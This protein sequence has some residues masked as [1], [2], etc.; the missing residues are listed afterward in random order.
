MTC[1]KGKRGQT[2]TLIERNVILDVLENF[3]ETMCKSKAVRACS[4]TT[5][6]S[7]RMIYKLAKEKELGILK[8]P[9]KC[10]RPHV[11]SHMRIMKYKS[12]VRSCIRRIVHSCFAQNIPP[13][14]NTILHTLNAVKQFP[15]FK[16]GTLYNLLKDIGFEYERRGGG[17]IFVER[18]D[19]LTY[20]HS[21]LQKLKEARKQD[22]PIIYTGELWVNMSKI[23][24]DFK[25]KEESIEQNSISQNP[26]PSFVLIIAG[27]INGF[28]KGAK[29]TLPC[30]TE[31]TNEREE[32]D[33]KIYENW[34]FRH[35][36]PH[37]PAD[38]IIVMDDT[39]YNSQRGGNVPDLSW[40]KS[41]VIE[42]LEKA[43]IEVDSTL[44]VSELIELV[45]G[46]KDD[47]G[48][49]KIDTK[50][51]ELGFEVLR[52]P[53]HHRELNP[54][55]MVWDQVEHYIK[56]NSSPF[57]KDELLEIVDNSYLNVTSDHWLNYVAE[58]KANENFLW[59]ADC[60]QEDVDALIHK[61]KWSTF[62]ELEPDSSIFMSCSITD[63]H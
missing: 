25:F 44:L 60:L 54:I 24:D 7:E 52:L 43:G 2:L 34:F 42:W 33:N 13:V 56:T 14:L 11:K 53:R 8:P 28:I 3:Q 57:K 26:S 29:L 58:V 45:N 12:D 21:Y 37:C 17:G 23:W 6:R 46:V 18:N 40:S 55:Y 61:L 59:E 39:K 1:I 50:C 31:R 63:Q 27:D 38:S 51:K 48:S 41:N 49:F 30:K 10:K 32:M 4:E 19:I 62:S 16:R 9:K 15:A 35:L 22:K 20:R 5:G 36:L 47:Y